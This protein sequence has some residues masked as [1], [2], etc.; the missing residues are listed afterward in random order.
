MRSITYSVIIP[1]KD[2]EKNILP[3][4]E[5]L[6]PVM[7]KLASPWELIAIDDGSKD[8]TLSLLLG[9][10]KQ[11]KEVRVVSFTR[12][13]GQ[14][15][16]FAA[17]FE[18]ARGEYI[19]TL[20]GDGQNDPADIPHL[21]K[22]KEKADLICGW[23]QNRI[24][25]WQKKIISFISNSI[26]SRLCQD[27]V[28]DTGCSLKL[29][30]KGA[31]EKIKLYHGMHRFFPALFQIEGFSVKEIAVNHRPRTKGKSKYHLFNRAIAPIADMFVVLWMRRRQLRYEISHKEPK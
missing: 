17:G 1:F 31:L 14:S 2:E 19:I 11:K 8:N 13:F 18:A 27:N 30:R 5:E 10:S 21:V 28:H 7:E 23:R 9:L 6:A 4:F 22:E 26:R 12:N 15:S 24:D 20:D 16:A 29:F 25:P 3:L